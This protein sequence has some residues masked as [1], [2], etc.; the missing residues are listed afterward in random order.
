M[1]ELSNLASPVR[2][3]ASKAWAGTVRRLILQSR[4][5]LDA[6]RWRRLKSIPTGHGRRRRGAK[7]L[8]FG[9]SRGPDPRALARIEE[10]R[11]RAAN[12]FVKDRDTTTLQDRLRI[13]DDQERDIKR[14]GKPS[15]CRLMRRC[16]TS[17]IPSASWCDAEDGDRKALA[18]SLF[19]A[20]YVLGS[21]TVMIA[22][23]REAAEH[24][25]VTT[26]RGEEFERSGRED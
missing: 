8:E 6:R 2:P 4:A 9:T 12:D 24:G 16:G 1:G 14:A 26:F 18:E 5:S 11:R 21:G 25:L 23:T 13:L 15:E 3:W 19:E 10:L 17:R 22:P 7:A 20:I